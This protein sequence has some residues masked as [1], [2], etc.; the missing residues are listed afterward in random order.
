MA[1]CV[2]LRVCVAVCGGGGGSCGA[3]VVGGGGGS[4]GAPVVVVE[5]GGGCGIRCA[6][7]VHPSLLVVVPVS[8]AVELAVNLPAAGRLG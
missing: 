3:P 8:V 2:G 5:Y 6:A 4:C 1:V 7:I